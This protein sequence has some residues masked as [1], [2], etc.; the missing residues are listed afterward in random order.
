MPLPIQRER[1]SGERRASQPMQ[2]A[3]DSASEALPRRQHATFPYEDAVFDEGDKRLAVVLDDERAFLRGY[4]T[5][6]HGRNFDVFTAA[7]ASDAIALCRRV[8]PAFLL[9]DGKMPE[10]SLPEMLTDL[11]EALGQNPKGTVVV[12]LWDEVPTDPPRA[13]IA[14]SLV[15]TAEPDAVLDALGIERPEPE[16]ESG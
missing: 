2:R 7:C 3:V 8:E 14:R 6:L 5:A 10:L 12:M 16:D 4:S 11:E 1:A 13:S 15:K 9:L